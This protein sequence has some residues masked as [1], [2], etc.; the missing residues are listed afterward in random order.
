[1]KLTKELILSKIKT[2]FEGLTF[3]EPSHT[4]YYKGEKLPSVSKL[5]K[6]FEEKTDWNAIAQKVAVKRKTTKE[7]ILAS[8][9]KEADISIIK[10]KKVHKYAECLGCNLPTI[11]EEQA[12]IDFW[13]DLQ[14]DYPNR[15]V[16]IA[17]EL[18]MFHH[19]YLYAGT[20]D[21]LLW[22]TQEDTLIIVDY[23]TNKDLF[24]NFDGKKLV[25]PFIE[26]LDHPYNHYQIQLSFYQHLIEQ[27]DIRVS[28]R[29]IIWINDK[30]KK[31]KTH[32]LTSTLITWLNS[33]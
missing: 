14:I 10:G 28:E 25:Q 15:Y 23:K 22:D 27:I 3:D 30:Y 6:L 19:Q 11:P 5:C 7:D 16:I 18:M 26:Y 1:M 17:Q 13:L 21:V 33:N 9:K 31:F 24:K 2:T 32:D 8:W 29:W 4:Y 20:C 12:L